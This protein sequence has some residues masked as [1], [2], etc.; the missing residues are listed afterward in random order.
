MP[1]KIVEHPVVEAD[2][3]DVCP[4]CGQNIDKRDPRAIEY[5]K[6]PRHLPYSGK[7]KGGWR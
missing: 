7:R 1:K 6:Q 2:V 5:H 3:P 4:S